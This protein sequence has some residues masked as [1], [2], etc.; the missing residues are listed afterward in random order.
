MVNFETN[1]G[2]TMVFN[3]RETAGFRTAG[4]EQQDC[5]HIEESTRSWNSPVFIVKKKSGK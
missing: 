2:Y 4:T 3:R 5:W 1:T